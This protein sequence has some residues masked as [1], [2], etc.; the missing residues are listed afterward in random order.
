MAYNYTSMQSSIAKIITKYGT[1]ITIVS[2]GTGKT[3]KTYAVYCGG[4][5]TSD[6]TDPT[7]LFT[8]LTVGTETAYIPASTVEPLPGD[9]VT[10]KGRSYRVLEVQSYCPADTVLAYVLALE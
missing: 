8:K 2:A 4:K 5:N 3:I 9:T 6:K 1:A 10:G 7:S